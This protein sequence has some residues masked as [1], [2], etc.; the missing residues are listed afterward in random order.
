MIFGIKDVLPVYGFL[1]TCK[2]M[3]TNLK[4][5]VTLDD[6]DGADFLYNYR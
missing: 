2:R 4:D 3:V 6:D 5:Y 1:K